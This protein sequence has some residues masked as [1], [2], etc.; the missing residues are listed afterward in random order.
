MNSQSIQNNDAPAT[1]IV[2][3]AN[4]VLANPAFGLHKYLCL[5]RFK[6]V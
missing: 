5:F 6:K 1:N 3:G 4:I 2:A